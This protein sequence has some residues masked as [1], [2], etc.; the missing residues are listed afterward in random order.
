VNPSDIDDSPDD[1]HLLRGWWVPGGRREGMT[2]AAWAR[3][4][5][6]YEVQTGEMMAQYRQAAEAINRA[7]VMAA[8]RRVWDS[9]DL[10]TM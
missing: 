10:W 9:I 2:S 7:D 8:R 4:R 3:V 6:A 1:I 5:A